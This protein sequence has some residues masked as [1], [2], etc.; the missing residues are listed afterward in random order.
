MCVCV[1]VGVSD[2][3]RQRERVRERGFVLDKATLLVTDMTRVFRHK[4][5][6][7]ENMMSSVKHLLAAMILYLTWHCPL[8]PPHC[9]PCPSAGF[10]HPLFIIEITG[11]GAHMLCIKGPYLCSQCCEAADSIDL[12]DNVNVSLFEF[13]IKLRHRG[14]EKGGCV[15]ELVTI[16]CW[17]GF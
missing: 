14:M 4:Y 11:P 2:I 10:P 16:L 1:W 15:S 5:Q 17:G 3:E 6:Q 13:R 12:H 9:L 8:H 7:S